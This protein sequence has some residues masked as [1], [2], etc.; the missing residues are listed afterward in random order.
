M[1]L[2]TAIN[3]FSKVFLDFP[4]LPLLS[5]SPDQRDAG[6]QKFHNII[7]HFERLSPD[8]QLHQR[9]DWPVLLRLTYEHSR[10]EESQEHFLQAFFSSISLPLDGE[11]VDF[12]KAGVEESL[13]PQIAR[14]ADYLVNNFFTPS[15]CRLIIEVPQSS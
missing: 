9:Y 3:P 5:L 8:Q 14:F 1:H 6:Q 12:S 4:S 15:K 10:S 7:D 2:I 11:D 13:Q